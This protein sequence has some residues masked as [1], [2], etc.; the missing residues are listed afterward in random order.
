MSLRAS[1]IGVLL[2]LATVAAP[3]QR[4]GGQAA[5]G[6]AVDA[7][8]R[9]QDRA[10][11][12]QE[13]AASATDRAASAQDR[14]AQAQERVAQAQDR[15]AQAQDRASQAQ[16][17]ST[18]A[19]QRSDR[20]AEALSRANEA[21]AAG[22]DVAVSARGATDR[23]R[24][25]A[26]ASPLALELIDDIAAV[27]GEVLALDP[28]PAVVQ[29]VVREGYSI[30]AEETIEGIDLRYVTFGVPAGRPLR[31]ALAQLRELAP[32]TEFTAN[33]IH[34]QSGPPPAASASARLAPD[35]RVEGPAIG[36]IDGGVADTAGVRRITQR[37]FAVGAPAPDAHGTALASLLASTRSVKSAAPGAPILVAD[38]YGG[39]PKGGS[40]LNLA[41][42]LGWM[43]SR[44]VP[45]VVVGLVGPSNPVVARAVKQVQARGTI[46][47]A[48]VGNAGAAAPPM[49]PAA[50]PEVIGVT[51]VD[52]RNRALVEA[53][54]GAHVDYAAP[55]ADIFA[56]GID[57]KRS[58][59]RGTSY[60][61]PLVAG[62]LWNA[63]TAANP[64]NALTAEVVDLGPGGRDE[65]FGHG[66]VC[67][68][69][70]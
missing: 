39:D 41:R 26:A 57:G 2:L 23:Y 59:V 61:A 15:V 48:P 43:A 70:R 60:A 25:M 46:V 1:T 62:R 58:S 37:G 31:A 36:L 21:G 18:A 7:A 38:V 8:V 14:A 63:R 27:R 6:Q 30:L 28:S 66:L 29:A 54:R 40:A 4:A 11:S 51:G 9:A 19:Q 32:G 53:G 12:A 65:V 55:G 52:R 49:F 44:G 24:E 45:V 22:R 42:A 3:V 34:L 10:A 56:A 35:T 47:V 17:R 16:E 64:L 67:G 69:C 68:R 13:R 50:Y 20:A 5:P 33:H